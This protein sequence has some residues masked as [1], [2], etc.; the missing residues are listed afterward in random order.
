VEHAADVGL[1]GGLGDEQ[2]ASD[3]RVRQ[4]PGH[5][6]EHLALALGELVELGTRGHR[7]PPGE[8][9]DQTAGDRGREQRLP[10]RDHAD[11]RDELL[12]GPVL[13]QE[14]ARLAPARK[15]SYT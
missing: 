10:R 1:H 8:L 9:L 6:D 15:A 2:R 11:R 13:Q 5:E 3:L 7:G 4:A 12:R 14:A